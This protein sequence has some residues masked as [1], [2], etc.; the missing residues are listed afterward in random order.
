MVLTIDLSSD[1]YPEFVPDVDDYVPVNCK[2]YD[3]DTCLPF[4]SVASFNIIM[5]NIR[6]CKRNFNTFISYFAQFLTYFS[7]IIL[8]ET[9]LTP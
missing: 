9:R 1:V 8:I 6:S 2:Y 4:L 5:F 7:C 3:F